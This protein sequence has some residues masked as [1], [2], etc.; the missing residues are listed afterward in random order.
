VTA[1]KRFFL[2]S[3]QIQVLFGNYSIIRPK[4]DVSH[5]NAATTPAS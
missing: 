1:V 3:S 5:W 2:P 4:R